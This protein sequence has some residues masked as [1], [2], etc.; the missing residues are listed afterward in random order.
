L[1]FTFTS[2]F[3]QITHIGYI[4]KSTVFSLFKK[5]PLDKGGLTPFQSFVTSLAATLGNGNIAGVATAITLG[6]PGSVFWMWISAIIGSMTAF[7]ENALGVYYRKENKKGN[8]RGGTMY[9]A[10]KAIRNKKLAGVV[11]VSF[12]FFCLL[13][14]FGMGNTVQTNTITS[15]INATSVYI[16]PKI[17]GI[18]VSVILLIAILGGS[19]RIARINEIFLPLI[20]VFYIIGALIIIMKNVN[21]LPKALSVIFEGA[22]GLGAFTG[23]AVGYTVKNAFSVGVR[24]GVFS[25]EAGIG[26]LVIINSET[27]GTTPKE[28]GMWGIF[29][30]QFDTIVMCSLTALA[31]LC[32]GEVDLTSG[33]VASG[34]DG[35]ALVSRAFSRSLGE[36]SGIFIAVSTVF[37]AFST[38]LGWSFYG[39]RCT[40]YLFGEKA[41]IIYKLTF[42]VAAYFGAVSDLR[43]IWVLSDIFNGLMA[44]PNLI[45]VVLLSS[46]VGKLIKTDDKALKI[47]K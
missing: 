7:A 5:R 22:F 40:E 12:A 3:F 44:V 33:V 8:L 43:F 42:S 30:T 38:L 20:S 35:A 9:L 10:Y 27:V 18:A 15:A 29:E 14:S 41:V 4:L 45:C 36:F 2:G 37:F 47:L 16:E 31:L 25:N 28:Q 32:S 13:A 6:G 21:L 23:G 24:R 39:I 46:T 34:C 11:S 17:I 1:Y 26:S 19:K